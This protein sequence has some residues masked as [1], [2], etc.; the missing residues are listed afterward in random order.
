MMDS[1][2]TRMLNRGGC[3]TDIHAQMPPSLSIPSLLAGLEL[4]VFPALEV[5]QKQSGHH[6]ELE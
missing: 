2:S 3:P 6:E 4:K 5:E 1:W